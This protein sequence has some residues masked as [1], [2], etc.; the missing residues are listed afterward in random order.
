MMESYLYGMAPITPLQMNDRKLFVWNGTNYTNYTNYRMA[1][2]IVATLN[3]EL[4]IPQ[5]ILEQMQK[6]R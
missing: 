3:G 5:Q 4:L 6:G 1:P 2:I